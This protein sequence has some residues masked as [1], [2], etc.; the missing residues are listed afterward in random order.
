MDLKNVII[1]EFDKHVAI[2]YPEIETM[3]TLNRKQSELV[4]QDYNFNHSLKKHINFRIHHVETLQPVI[5]YLR[6]LLDHETN[7][8]TLLVR[9]VVSVRVNLNNFGHEDFLQLVEKA[10]D[11]I[12]SM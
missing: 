6:F 10:I 12:K 1:K 8:G 9:Y 3:G 11:K 2:E 5:Y 4:D 7:K